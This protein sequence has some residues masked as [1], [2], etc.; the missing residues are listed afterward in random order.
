MVAKNMNYES[1]ASGRKSWLCHLLPSCS[2]LLNMPR[3]TVAQFPLL[4][5]RE[6]SDSTFLRY[7][8]RINEEK[9]LN[10]CQSL[11][12]PQASGSQLRE[13]FMPRGHLAVL[14]NI[15]DC[16]DQKWRLLLASSVRRPAILQN[17]LPCQDNPP[18]QSLLQTKN[19]PEQRSRAPKV[20]TPG[21]STTMC[22][23][24]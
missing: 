15:L 7:V 11:L 19:Y 17:T 24:Q 13:I 9:A 4:E 8:G 10:K 21:H 3:I 1:G 22:L 23:I 18:P 2:V 6:K 5:N 12:S 14:E 20:V 16:Q